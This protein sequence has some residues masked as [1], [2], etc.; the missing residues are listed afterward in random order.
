MREDDGEPGAKSDGP[1]PA[2]AGPRLSLLPQTSAGNHHLQVYAGQKETTAPIVKPPPFKEIITDHPT[3][4][5]RTDSRVHWE[6][7]LLI[8]PSPSR[9]Q[10]K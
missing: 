8:I 3:D 4:R 1:G 6:V 7:S 5:R 9:R 2:E 10:F